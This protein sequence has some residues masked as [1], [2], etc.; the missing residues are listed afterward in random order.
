ML[1]WLFRPTGSHGLGTAVLEALLSETSISTPAALDAVNISTFDQQPSQTELGVVIESGTTI[2][3]VEIKTQ[4]Q[5]G[6]SQCDRQVAYLESVVAG[7]EERPAGPFD[8]WEYIYLSVDSD[9]TPEY[10]P[11]QVTWDSLLE[12]VSAHVG[13]VTRDTDAVRIREWVRFASAQ[14]LESERLSPATEL[15]LA[16]PVMVDQHDLNLNFATVRSDR[17]RL[18]SSVWQ[19]LLETHPS[20]ANGEDGWATSRSRIEPGTKYVRL[21]KTGWP[22]GMR[23]EIQATEQRLTAGD[24]H[25]GSKNEYRT[26]SP[27]IEVTLTYSDRDEGE[28]NRLLSHLAGDGDE[29]LR[30]HGF[31]LIRDVLSED[32]PQFNSH[33][34]YSKQV[35]VNFSNPAQTVTG[36]RQGVSSLLELEQFIDRF[37]A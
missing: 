31:E 3:A 1:A 6:R 16:F 37:K 36:I 8:S 27:H 19:W 22:W 21:L 28:R 14:L 30:N 17:Q 11:H 29:L 23:F 15:Q 34:V 24:N 33:H 20:V 9:H 2:V 25:S 4:G 32:G 26:R 13:A 7:D 5:L 35:P 10:V 18:L 12:H